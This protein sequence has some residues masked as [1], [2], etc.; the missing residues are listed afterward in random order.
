[1][2]RLYNSYRNITIKHS[3]LFL[4][5]TWTIHFKTKQ[6]FLRSSFSFTIDKYKNKLTNNTKRWHVWHIPM[7]FLLLVFYLRLWL[8]LINFNL[9]FLFLVFYLPKKK[10]Y[11]NFFSLKYWRFHFWRF[12]W[13]FH[14]Y[15]RFLF[16]EVNWVSR[17]S[18]WQVTIY[19]SHRS[20]LPWLVSPSNIVI[21]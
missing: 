3:N 18:L 8:K 10:E 17:H 7:L 11:F 14:F 5:F 4:Y 9:N 6:F 2:V 1:M 16:F 19:V 21:V 12:H 15:W 13:R 20:C